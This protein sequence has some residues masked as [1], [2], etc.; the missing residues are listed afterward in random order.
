MRTVNNE[1]L[2]RSALEVANSAL[3]SGDV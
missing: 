3:A 2:M 1:D